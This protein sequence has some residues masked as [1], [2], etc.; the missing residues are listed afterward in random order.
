MARRMKRATGRY[1]GRPSDD[2]AKLACGLTARSM[3]GRTITRARVCVESVLSYPR[4]G[5]H[6]SVV[7]VTPRPLQAQHVVVF[8]WGSIVLD[9]RPLWARDAMQSNK[10]WGRARP[11]F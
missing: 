7:V 8:V 6:L 10:K 5:A 11:D 2:R 9:G 4:R 3:C 1:L